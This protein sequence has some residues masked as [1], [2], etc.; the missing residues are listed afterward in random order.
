MRMPKQGRTSGF[1]LV[2]LMVTIAVATVLLIIATPSFTDFIDKARLRGVTGNAVDFINAARA[3]SVKQGRDVNVAF[4]GTVTAW[5]IGANVAAEPTSQGDAIP[6]VS[7]CDCSGAP[8]SCL[9]AGAQSTLDS[10]SING[11]AINA[12]PASFVFD[13]RLGTVLPL[14]TTVA[15]FS[16]PR[17]K[18]DLQLTITP[19]GQVSV[20][21]PA[22]SKRAF[23]EYPSC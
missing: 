19:I 8:A 3:Q 1:T 16:S 22:S 9:V 12:I 13:S 11:V 5:C 7:A 4:G 10:S 18:F 21:V 2:E 20:C 6:A 23:S 15:T 14:G 17:R